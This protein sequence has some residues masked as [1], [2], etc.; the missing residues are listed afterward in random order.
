MKEFHID[1]PREIGR[2]KQRLSRS[3]ILNIKDELTEVVVRKK[4]RELI[5]KELKKEALGPSDEKTVFL[6]LKIF[7]QSWG[8]NFGNILKGIN[9][10]KIGMIKKG[11][12]EI[13]ILHNKIEKEIEKII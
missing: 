3:D 12:K 5:K 1:E 10:G 7:G 8:V 9:R 6:M 13:T 11:L 2:K 4:I